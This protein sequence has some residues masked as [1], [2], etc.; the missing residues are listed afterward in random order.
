[1][2]QVRM[3]MMMVRTNPMVV[4]NPMVVS[5]ILMQD[6]STHDLPISLDLVM[7]NAW[8]IYGVCI[9]GIAIKEGISC[10]V[11]SSNH[12]HLNFYLCKSYL[13]G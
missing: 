5:T 6:M 12:H 10:R 11:Q 7:L 1:M 4:P 13:P 8:C 2:L 3:A 9:A